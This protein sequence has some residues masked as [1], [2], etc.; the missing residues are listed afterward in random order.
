MSEYDINKEIKDKTALVISEI[1]ELITLNK[2][3][4]QEDFFGLIFEIVGKHNLDIEEFIEMIEVYPTV[5]TSI[6]RVLLEQH[7][8]DNIISQEVKESFYLRED[9]Y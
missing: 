6:G 7:Y 8:V 4:F 2:K 9:L 3:E 5:K 1:E